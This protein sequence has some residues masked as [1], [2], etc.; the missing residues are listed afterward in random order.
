MYYPKKLYSLKFNKVAF[1]NVID[2]G[3]YFD[4]YAPFDFY[5]IITGSYYAYKHVLQKG[6]ISFDNGLNNEL[7]QEIKTELNRIDKKN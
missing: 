7:I 3:M 5:K 2:N 4:G 6:L 1:G